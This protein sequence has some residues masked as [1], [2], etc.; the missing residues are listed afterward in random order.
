MNL[1]RSNLLAE[2]LRFCLWAFGLSLVLTGAATAQTCYTSEDMDAATHAALTAAGKHYFEL[3]SK[4]DTAALKQSAIA[5]LAADFSSVETAVKDNQSDF[6]G[7]Q[8]SPRPEFLLKVEGAAP[9][10]RAEFLCGVFGKNGQ[11]ASSA[12]FVIPNLLPGTYAIVME[13]AST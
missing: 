10:E 9:L 5:S 13:D 12:E 7:T 3:A 8:P 11:T 1:F 6:S 4:G 2:S